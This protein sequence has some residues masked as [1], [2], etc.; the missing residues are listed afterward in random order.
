MTSLKNRDTESESD[1]Q[2]TGA[3]VK[4]LKEEWEVSLVL[5]EM[6]EQANKQTTNERWMLS[7]NL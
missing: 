7:M 1:V 5:V 2:S 3:M 4:V 6:N